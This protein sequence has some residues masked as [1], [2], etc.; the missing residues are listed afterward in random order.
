MT[1]APIIECE[2]AAA[3][4]DDFGVFLRCEVQARPALTSIYWLI[5]DNSTVVTDGES[6]GD[7]WSIDMVRSTTQNWTEALELRS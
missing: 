3:Y 6:V 2:A 1:D 5:D 7:Y 4:V